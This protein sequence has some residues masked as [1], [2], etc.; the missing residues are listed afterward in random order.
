VS[1]NL[2]E[3]SDRLLKRGGEVGGRFDV[4]SYARIFENING[5]GR[6]AGEKSSEIGLLPTVRALES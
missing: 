1:G 6:G 4:C 3:D 2:L 5:L